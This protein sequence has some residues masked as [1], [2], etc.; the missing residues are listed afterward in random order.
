MR[1][2]PTGFPFIA[3]GA[4]D[5]AATTGEGGGPAWKGSFVSSSGDIM[6]HNVITWMKWTYSLKGKNYQN[7]KEKKPP[8][9]KSINEIESMINNRPK[10]ARAQMVSLVNSTKYISKK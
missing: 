5:H 8:E 1:A 3:G 7:S 10:Q 4:A 2:K 6:N 9:S